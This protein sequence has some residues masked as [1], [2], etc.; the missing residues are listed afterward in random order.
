MPELEVE[1]AEI[2][3]TSPEAPQGY[4]IGRWVARRS[5]WLLSGALAVALATI[6]VLG[7]WLYLDH[8]DTR[9]V[10]EKAAIAAVMAYVDAANA[11]DIDGML[12]NL[13]PAGKVVFLGA[14]GVVDGPYAGETLAIAARA[15]INGFH[16][17]VIGEPVVLTPHRVSM[18]L[19][20]TRVGDDRVDVHVYDLTEVDGALKVYTEMII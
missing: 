20:M 12:A 19:H 5:T 18:E 8:R 6:A 3:G 2:I 4:R 17:E 13:A 15:T 9:T 14:E 7:T 11:H 16:L 10:E 1:S